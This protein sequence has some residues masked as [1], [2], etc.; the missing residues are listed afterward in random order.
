MNR[1]DFLRLLMAS[2]FTPTLKAQYSEPEEV[3]KTQK[4]MSYILLNL[5]ES[6]PRWLFD[7]PLIDSPT[8]HPM[9]CTKIVNGKPTYKT[10]KK[11]NINFPSLWENKTQSLSSSPVPMSDLLDQMLII[12]GCNM[13][14][15][16]HDLNSR[17]L[18]STAEGKT[19]IGGRIADNY[20]SHFPALAVSGTMADPFKSVVSSFNTEKG[21]KAFICKEENSKNYIEQAL[22]LYYKTSSSQPSV[23]E[24]LEK[25]SSHLKDSDPLSYQKIRELQKLPFEK[26]FMFFN[27]SLKKY[28]ELLENSYQ[29]DIIKD[30]SDQEIPAI[31]FPA[32][33]KL[34]EEKSKKP[35]DYMGAFQFERYI[36]TGSDL[37][38]VF[39]K[40]RA[41]NIA[42]NFALAETALKF[43]LTNVLILNFDPLTNIDIRN[44]APVNE[45][46]A[47]IEN[48]EITFDC[49]KDK[50]FSTPKEGMKMTFDAHFIGT[51]PGLIGYSYYFQHFCAGLLEFK[52]FLKTTKKEG[53]NLFQNSLVHLT[54][55]FE[56]APQK[57]QA[58]SDHGWRGHTSTF[59]SGRFDSGV[60]LLGKITKDSTN[61][62]GNAYCTWGA[63]A[64]FPPIKREMRYGDIVA[65]IA[66]F[67]KVPPTQGGVSLLKYKGEKVVPS[68]KPQGEA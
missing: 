13:N 55:E 32:R 51:Y 34:D 58:G 68:F 66:S 18:E 25:I 61:A 17:V 29:N 45:I 22:D 23:R 5:Y 16:G 65:S 44:A 63:A 1:K 30:L 60:K 54:S 59:F 11:G 52:R 6:P 28:N 26:I 50:L 20:P 56:R 43:S 24:L 12:R 48:D 8:P 33:F 62:L 67:F 3:Q 14:K 9:I 46:T 4:E 49:P 7:L 41:D 15:D 64:D 31:K 37:N 10:I 36:L 19:S 47:K 2:L 42:K 35:L 53:H 21:L 38:R 40:R 57:N 39:K 27:K